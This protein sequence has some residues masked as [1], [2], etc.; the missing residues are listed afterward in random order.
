MIET[1]EN[2]PVGVKQDISIAATNYRAPDKL[3]VRNKKPNKHYA[4]KGKNDKQFPAA[5]TTGFVPCI[6]K[7]VIAPYALVDAEGKKTVGDLMLM[8]KSKE[9]HDKEVAIKEYVANIPMQQVTQSKFIEDGKEND[10][11]RGEVKV[12]KRR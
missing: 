12:S 1:K 6:D 7:D 8:E 3:E 10:N 9:L 11:I 5:L 2:I 4:W